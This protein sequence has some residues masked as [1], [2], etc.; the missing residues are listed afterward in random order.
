MKALW[1]LCG[2]CWRPWGK[3]FILARL[4]AGQSCK[5]SKP[6]DH[7]PRSMLGMCEGLLYAHQA[8]LDLEEYIKAIR[9]GGGK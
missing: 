6:G 9:N 8:G 4:G 5:G 1:G 3:C 7:C 2:R